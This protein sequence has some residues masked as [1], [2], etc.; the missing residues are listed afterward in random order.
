MWVLVIGRDIYSHGGNGTPKKV[1]GCVSML[2]N[3]TAC[4]KNTRG[5]G[6]LTIFA[7][8]VSTFIYRTSDEETAFPLSALSHT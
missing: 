2:A 4:G 6:V 7:A 3:I 5:W 1:R 8:G